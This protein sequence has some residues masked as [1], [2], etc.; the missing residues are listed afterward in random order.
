M[1]RILQGAVDHLNLSLERD[2]FFFL[3]GLV[4]L[5]QVTS[6]VCIDITS[7]A[8][9]GAGSQHTLAGKLQ[10]QKTRLHH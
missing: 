2:Y 9:G 4:Y 6:V 10:Q 8:R 3:R 7:N 5:V 1:Q